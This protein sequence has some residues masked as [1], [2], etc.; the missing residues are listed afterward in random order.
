VPTSSQGRRTNV[1]L[2]DPFNVPPITSRSGPGERTTGT[3]VSVFALYVQDQVE[4]GPVQLIGGLR[5]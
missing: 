4:I 5:W 2:G 1:A 3:D